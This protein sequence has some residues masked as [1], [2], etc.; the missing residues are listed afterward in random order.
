MKNR[1]FLFVF[2]LNLSITVS[3]PLLG[4]DQNSE[5]EIKLQTLTNSTET[6]QKFIEMSHEVIEGQEH[7]NFL[8]D[9]K[10]SLN[11]RKKVI[12]GHRWISMNS[13][14]PL[15]DVV[16]D[17]VM[18]FGMTHSLEMA[19]GPLMVAIGYANSWPTWLVSLLGAAGATISVPGLDPLCIVA[20]IT[21]GKSSRFRKVIRSVRFATVRGMKTATHFLHLSQMFNHIIETNS[22]EN[23][24]LTSRGF[25]RVISTG[26]GTKTYELEWNTPEAKINLKVRSSEGAVY[27]TQSQISFLEIE[28]KKQLHLPHQV[29]SELKSLG[30][31]SLLSE[32]TQIAQSQE[33]EKRFYM[34]S[35]EKKEGSLKVGFKE[36]ALKIYPKYEVRSWSQ[37]NQC[38]KSLQAL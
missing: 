37:A 6:E 16:F 27:V 33:A 38:R 34:E 17:S 18:L 32:L 21:Y 13:R 5:T 23:R 35:L 2:I 1:L 20:F 22:S 10:E 31:K 11:F 15:K 30:L 4:A 28:N 8:K 7:N 36:N 19:S 12:D 14:G 25:K 24:I 9:F 3:T 26:N 29:K